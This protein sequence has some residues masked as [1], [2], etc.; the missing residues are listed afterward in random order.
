MLSDLYSTAGYAHGRGSTNL[1]QALTGRTS[2]GLVPDLGNLH[3]ACIWENIV[4][5]I[6]LRAKGVDSSTVANIIAL[7]SPEGLSDSTSSRQFR[8]ISSVDGAT[9]S[10]PNGDRGESE[11]STLFG[12][13]TPSKKQETVDTPRSLNSKAVSH[14]LHQIPSSLAPLFQGEINPSKVILISSC[15]TNSCCQT[16]SY[17]TSP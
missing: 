16:L 1:L 3:R 17:E 9:S 4:F 6:G 10:V 2:P 14:V 11:P 5:K 7:D 8:V 15:A 13:F 12:G